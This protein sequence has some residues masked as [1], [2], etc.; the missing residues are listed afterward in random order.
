L[1]LD[2]SLEPKEVSR[3]LRTFSFLAHGI[4]IYINIT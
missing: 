1:S 2:L 3:S 4:G